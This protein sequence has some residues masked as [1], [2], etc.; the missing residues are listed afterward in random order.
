M[1][2]IT[3][4]DRQKNNDKRY[5]VFIDDKFSFGIDEI[6]LL[7]YKLQENIEIT[8][9]R[10]NN[11]INN[12][13]VRKAKDVAL[14]YLSYKMRSKF[15][16]VEK[17]K[18]SE[19]SEE[20]I[21]KVVDFLEQYNYLN[22]EE[23]AKCYIKDKINLKGYGS[24]KIAYNLKLLGIGEDI[25]EKYLYDTDFVDEIS[26]IKMLISKKLGR[27]YYAGLEEYNLYD[28]EY[29]EKYKLFNYLA[30]RGFSYDNINT[31]F[32]KLQEEH[33]YE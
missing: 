30:R 8:E 14:K 32:S 11:I 9:E 6:D 10:Y 21:L 28:M 12:V 26:K 17:L 16:V 15:E 4:I 13:I 5:S 3:K 27:G 23:F 7:Y 33:F 2:K 29:K 18:K 1:P 20:V 22:D 19:F 25:Y 31:A 24:F